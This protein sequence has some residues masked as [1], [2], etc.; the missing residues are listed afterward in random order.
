M[1]HALTITCYKHPTST[2]PTAKNREEIF[3]RKNT[4]HEYRR[5]SILQQFVSRK[6]ILVGEQLEERIPRFANLCAYIPR[7]RPWPRARGAYHR[8]CFLRAKG[9]LGYGIRE[10]ADYRKYVAEYVRH[11]WHV[12]ALIFNPVIVP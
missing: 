4:S 1:E 9:K 10:A 2:K 11:R 5:I 12:D 6:N 8:S 3:P 7:L